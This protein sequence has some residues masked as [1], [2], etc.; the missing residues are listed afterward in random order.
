MRKLKKLITAEG[1]T[2]ETISLKKFEYICVGKQSKKLSKRKLTSTILGE[3][4]I[5]LSAGPQHLLGKY[6]SN[7]AR[8]KRAATARPLGEREAERACTV[9]VHQD[10]HLREEEIRQ[11]QSKIPN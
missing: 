6:L 7:I 8:A 11:D 1:I 3:D 2:Q 4:D 5:H 9:R 10:G